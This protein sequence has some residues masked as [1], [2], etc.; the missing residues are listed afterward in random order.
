MAGRVDDVVAGDLT[1]VGGD[2]PTAVGQ[3]GNTDDQGVTGD[4]GAQLAGPGS[5]S[6]GGAGGVGPAVVRGPEAEYDVVD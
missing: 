2:P 3:L 5:H 4:L 1:L 6:V